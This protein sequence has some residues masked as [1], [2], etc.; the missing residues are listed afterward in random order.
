MDKIGSDISSSEDEL[1]TGERIE[2]NY[3]PVYQDADAKYDA[4]SEKDDDRMSLSSLSS[5]EQKIEE[6]KIETIQPNIPTHPHFPGAPFNPYQ[7]YP[8]MFHLLWMKVKIFCIKLFCM[9]ICIQ[10]QSLIMK[11]LLGKHA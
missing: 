10:S 7:Q 9:Y 1:L 4:K 3:S 11:Y 8:G 5:N 2:N 6:S